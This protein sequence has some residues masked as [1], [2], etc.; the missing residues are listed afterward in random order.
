V[1][2]RGTIGAR[3]YLETDASLN[4]AQ[5]KIVEGITLERAGGG[6]VL[7]SPSMQVIGSYTVSLGFL[8][9]PTLAEGLVLLRGV[10]V[11]RRRHGVK[12]L[13]A[14]SDCS[15]L[16]GL[17]NG[18]GRAGDPTLSSVV[19]QIALER[20]QLE[21]FELMWSPSSHA[22]EREAG[23]PS[24]DAIAR[25]AAGLASRSWHRARPRLGSGSVE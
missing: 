9:S 13:R 18:T 21:G 10:R 11:A 4:P 5:R 6:I 1:T 15:A 25:H 16:V 23:V 8:S 19:E 7:R 20:D 3:H 17:V 12:V 22:P 24:A 2:H 14:R